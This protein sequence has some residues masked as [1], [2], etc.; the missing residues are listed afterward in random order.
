[1]STLGGLSDKTK[2]KWTRY[3][4][5]RQF[6]TG[7]KYSDELLLEELLDEKLKTLDSQEAIAVSGSVG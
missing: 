5:L 3:K 4:G 6:Q 7:R 2:E 1:M